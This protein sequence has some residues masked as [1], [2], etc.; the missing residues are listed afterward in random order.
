MAVNTLEQPSTVYLKSLIRNEAE[1]RMESDVEKLLEDCPAHERDHYLE[2]NIR[3]FKLFKKFL[4]NSEVPLVWDEIQPFPKGAL[5]DYNSFILPSKAMMRTQLGK[6]V[7]VKLNGGLGTRMK[8]NG[9]KSLIPIR[10]TLTFLDLTVQQIENLNAEFSTNVPLVLMNSFNTSEETERMVQ[11]YRNFR[12]QVHTFEQSRHPRIYADSLNIVPNSYNDEDKNAWCPPGHGDFYESFVKSGLIEKFKENG[13][14]YCFVSNIDN[15]G[16]TIDFKILNILTNATIKPKP[17]FLMELTKK[18]FADTKGGTL[19]QYQGNLKL[20]EFAEVPKDHEEDFESTRIFNNFNTNNLWIKL[21][22]I[23]RI[24]ESDALPLDVIANR[25][26]I[27][28]NGS[29]VE[30]IQLETAAGA[31]IR[32]FNDATGIMVPRSRFLPVKATS[33]LFLLR[34]NIYIND[35]GKLIIN[36]L[37]HFPEVPIVS[38]SEDHF[39]DYRDLDKRF[40]NIPNC[41]QL[42][43]LSICGD[44]YFG[45]DVTLIGNVTIVANNGQRVDIPRGSV[46]QYK[47][48]TGALRIRNI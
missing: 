46:L 45:K 7:V 32:F 19:I 35:N 38:L 9:P 39:G 1:S 15:L 13:R 48:V 47:I 10:N 6:L 28:K 40:G 31:A 24:V 30:V 22:A 37:R 12:L 44:V 41:L 29:K 11:K 8:C 34:S 16:A 33:D 26:F 27:S 4:S 21:D 2:E 17:D 23:K 5:L 3:F 18:T 42:N 36:P 14:E 20:L 43:H 25:K